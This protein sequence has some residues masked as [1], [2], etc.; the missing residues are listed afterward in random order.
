MVY[1]LASAQVYCMAEKTRLENCI[2]VRRTWLCLDGLPVSHCID[3]P[4]FQTEISKSTA[5]PRNSL[6]SENIT[7]LRFETIT[8]NTQYIYMDNNKTILWLRN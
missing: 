4:P 6:V 2:V 7:A 3:T 1:A 8:K 5:Q